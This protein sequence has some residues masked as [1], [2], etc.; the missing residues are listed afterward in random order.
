M[1]RYEAR[2]TQA[3]HPWRATA[4]T[5]VAA[6]VGLAALTPTIVD[7]LGIGAL[8]WAA[9]AVAVAGA[10]TRILAIPGVIDWTRR[11]LPWLAPGDD[12]D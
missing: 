2:P 4:R 8:P 11:F 6:I 5:V 1:G 9:A 7:E 10:V 3:A 12:D